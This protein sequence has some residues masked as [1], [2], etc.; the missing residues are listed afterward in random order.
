MILGCV[1]DLQYSSICNQI[2]GGLRDGDPDEMLEGVKC[3]FEN[4]PYDLQVKYEKYY[5]SLFVSIFLMLKAR[6][7][8][9]V[10]TARGRIDAVI[11]TPKFV[12]VM[13]FK[14]R[15]TSEEALAQIDEK[16]Y[17][18]RFASDLRKLFKIGCAFDWEA[19]NLGRWLIV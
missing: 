19:R 12:Y 13:E 8:C 3:F 7:A 1:P 9:E 2:Y 5:Q 15:G 18:D 11:E 6:V 14:V 4:I 17:A 16:G 10:K